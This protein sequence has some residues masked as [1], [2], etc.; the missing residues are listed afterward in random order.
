[1]NSIE[2]CS[3][4]SSINTSEI[5]SRSTA[6]ELL[7]VVGYRSFCCKNCGFIWSQFLPISTL[8]NLIYLLL[9]VEIGFLLLS[10][11]R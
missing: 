2:L 8:L 6:A 3:K 11:L 9:A 10:Y 4:C 5:K 7:K 1:M